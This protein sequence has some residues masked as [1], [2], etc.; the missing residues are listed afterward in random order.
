MIVA[1]SIGNRQKLSDRSFVERH[2]D[3]FVTELCRQFTR[4]ECPCGD[5]DFVHE[6]AEVATVGPSA[7]FDALIRRCADTIGRSATNWVAVLVQS[8][9]KAIKRHRDLLPL[10]NRQ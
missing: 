7:D 6:T 5:F 2:V 10:I 1:G 9:V 3:G 8:N 4:F